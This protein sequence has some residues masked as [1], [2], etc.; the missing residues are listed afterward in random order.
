MVINMNKKWILLVFILALT[1]FIS[2][3]FVAAANVTHKKTQ[4]WSKITPGVA[5]IMKITNPEIGFKQINITVKNQANNVRITVTK[6]DDKPASVVHEIVGKV[7]KYME[8]TA[9]KINETHIDKVKIQFEVNKTWINDNN[10]DPDTVA[11]NRYRVN[12]WEKLQTRKT[13]EDNEYAYYEADASGFST[14]AI[15][16]EVEAEVTTTTP[17]E[18][19]TTTIAAITTT[20]SVFVA[21]TGFSVWVVVIV[22]IIIAGVAGF[23]LYKKRLILK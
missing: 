14:F 5:K 10:I 17:L 15:T 11:L 3:V 20:L 16:G 9:E 8:I 21:E 1:M 18:V 7:Y 13:S 6:L 2:N 23:W 4:I 12:A 19:T 22:I